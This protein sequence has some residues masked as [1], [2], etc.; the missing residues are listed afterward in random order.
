MTSSSNGSGRCQVS[1][2]SSQRS[3]IS[4]WAIAES[5]L[6]MAERFHREKRVKDSGKGRQAE[7]PPDTERDHP[8][9]WVSLMVIL[10][11]LILMALGQWDFVLAGFIGLIVGNGLST[12]TGR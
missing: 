9:L 12:F 11:L 1:A 10:A 3:A 8:R 7:K 4:G 2:V 6:L 5:E